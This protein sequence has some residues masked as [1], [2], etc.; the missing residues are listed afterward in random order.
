ML[1][2]TIREIVASDYADQLK[3]IHSISLDDANGEVLCDS[4]F[5]CWDFDKIIQGYSRDIGIDAV[6]LPDLL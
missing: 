5:E 4:S 3:P 2:N 6:S 1:I